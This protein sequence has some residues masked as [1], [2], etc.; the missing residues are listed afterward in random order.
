MLSGTTKKIAI[1][2]AAIIVL[3]TCIVDAGAQRRRRKRRRA[4]S[5]PV[6]TNPAITAPSPAPEGDGNDNQS[7]EPKPGEDPDSMR[8][9][10]RTLSNQVD[11]LNDKIDNM[12]KSQR[13]LADLERLTLAEQRAESLRSQLSD[14]LTKE[15]EVQ[16]RLENI[17]NA[18]LPQNIDRYVGG[19]G[20]THPEDARD[21]R[22]K[23]LESEKMRART[24][25]DT[26][27]Q[28]HSRLEASVAAADVEVDK[29]RKR[30]DA[31]DEAAIENAKKKGGTGSPQPYASP[32]PTPYP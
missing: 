27:M 3:T 32:T 6:I 9:T 21:Q 19:I 23:Q 10:I 31:A 29:I 8:Q 24:Q 30:L 20:T 7:A 17:D 14:V 11:R 18:L 26:L 1:A 13:S 2:L 16:A 28:N 15:G 12:E 25:L 4:P 22:R 5:T